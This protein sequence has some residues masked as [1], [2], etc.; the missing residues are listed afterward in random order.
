MENMQNFIPCQ[1][2]SDTKLNR[3]IDL[4]LRRFSNSETYVNLHGNRVIA[5]SFLLKAKILFPI[6]NIALILNLK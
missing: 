4:Y 5:S 6:A 1:C 2:N 3:C